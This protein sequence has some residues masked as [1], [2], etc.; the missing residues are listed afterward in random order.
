MPN[1]FQQWVAV[2]SSWLLILT[3]AL[4]LLALIQLIDLGNGSLR[5]SIDPSLDAI[6]T[7]SQSDRDYADLIHLRFGNREPVMVVLQSEDIYSL[8]N[9]ARLDR[10]SRA[11]KSLDGVETVSSLTATSIPRVDDGV[12]SYSRLSK[13]ALRDPATPGLLRNSSE[14]NPL[15]SGQL[16]SRDGK[17]AVI[18]VY[19]EPR[20]ELDLMRSRLAD[21]ILRTADIERTTGINILVTGPLVIRSE[22]SDTVA[23]QLRIV[24]PAIVVLI[25]L[26]LA[27]VFRSFRGV[28]LP[29]ATIAI[30]LIWILATLS[31]LGRPIN[32]ITALVPPFIVTM[33]L[34]Y[35]AHVLTEY[36]HLIRKDEHMDPVTRIT[37]L[38]REVSVPVTVTGL[39]TITGLLALTLNEQRSMIEF[40]WASALGTAYLMLLT[41]T[42]V[43]AMLRYI[44]P[45]HPL[46]PLPARLLF[47][48]GGERLSHFDQ[49]RRPLILWLAL[50][51]FVLSLVLASRIEIGDIFV[52]LFPEDARVRM[53][54]QTISRVMGGANP[55]DISIEGASDDVFTDPKVLR[56]LDN[57]QIWLSKQPEV[58][59]VNGLADHVKM[60]NRY[61]ADELDGGIPQSRNAIR[62]ML[63]VGEGELLRGVVNIDRSATLVQVRLTVDD[64]VSIGKFLNRLKSQLDQL[65]PGLTARLTGGA[66]VMTESVRTAT[67][68]QLMSVGLALGLIYLALSAQFMSFK[69]GLLATLPTAL[70]T[71]MYFGLLGLLGVPL[72]PTTVLVECLVLG[73][74]IDDTI[75]YLARF[76]S[77]AKRS[78]SETVAAKT[79]LQAV[80]R[81]VTVTKAIL[82]LGFLTMV[83]G[84]L[85][86]Q[87]QFGWLAALT[88]FCAWIVDIFVTPALMSG[89]RIVTLWDTLRL[90]LGDQVQQTVP[91]FKGLSNRQARVFALMSNLHYLPAGTRLITEGDEAGSIYVVID[92]ELSVFKGSGDNRVEYGTVKRGDVVGEVGYFGQRRMASVDTVTET[93]LLRFDDEDQERLCIAYPAIASR[94][95]LSLNRIQAQRQIERGQL[96]SSLGWDKR[97]GDKALD[98][99]STSF[100]S[101]LH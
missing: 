61:L 98:G 90:N 88:L 20:S 91:L 26:L 80:L 47:E 12:L 55:V 35:C 11:L 28:L 9:L 99:D 27:L 71:A 33:G 36:E 92:G 77:A 65:P 42:F 81:P 25:T 39:A 79:A 94:V 48:V 59:S 29:I 93:R 97:V 10:L 17:S 83:T 13:E 52:G 100:D 14:D 58:G 68:G 84:E 86:N 62:Q 8:D 45:G 70:Q 76:A 74:A 6:S 66:V 78:G 32:L 51:A 5:L 85:S 95:F 43:P 40:A 37:R 23:R 38:L 49:K 72:N 7:Q 87:A 101:S 15:I 82:A 24:V 21:R 57:L 50:G 4:T 96:K 54:Y 67:S 44:R 22:I 73:L 31:F 30:A 16:V 41:Q 46:K 75:H 89:L 19:L 18:L 1:Q 3:A 69:V 2:R 60:L 34:A 53:D 56:A 64:T 63:F